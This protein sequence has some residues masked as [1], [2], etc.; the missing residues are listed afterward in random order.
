VL[1]LEIG[2]LFY[3]GGAVRISPFLAAVARKGPAR[4]DLAAY[5]FHFI[6]LHFGIWHRHRAR[7]R[8]EGMVWG[9]SGRL[10]CTFLLLFFERTFF[11]TF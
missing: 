10:F 6:A 9:F 4:G 3:R 1:Y 2:W 7:K 5:L 11:T 8:S